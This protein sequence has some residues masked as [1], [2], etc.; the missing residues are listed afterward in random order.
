MQSSDPHNSEIF[1]LLVLAREAHAQ[2]QALNARNHTSQAA[3][4]AERGVLE[5]LVRDGAQSVPAIARARIVSRQHIQK[6]VDDLIARRL[7]ELQ[8]NPAHKT[9]PLVEVTIEGERAYTM[10]ASREASFLDAIAPE[11][12]KTDLGPSLAA[13]RALVAALK[14]AQ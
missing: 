2:W 9:S 5:I 13:M 7:V 8:P 11:L 3:T 14:P 6:L 1:Q 4:N 12:A 10:A